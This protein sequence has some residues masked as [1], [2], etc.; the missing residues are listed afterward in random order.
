[1][2][3]YSHQVAVQARELTLVIQGNKE[4]ETLTLI[5]KSEDNTAVFQL[6]SKAFSDVLALGGMEFL[7]RTSR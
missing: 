7:T 1:M 4:L 2:Y 5:T 6:Y 3:Y